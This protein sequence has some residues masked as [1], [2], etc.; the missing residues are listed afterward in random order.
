MGFLVGRDVET[1]AL[2]EHQQ[3]RCM[4]LN[5]IDGCVP[6]VC[7]FQQGNVVAAAMGKHSVRI[8]ERDNLISRAMHQQQGAMYFADAANGG[9]AT[10]SV[11]DDPL[12]I[13]IHQPDDHA[14]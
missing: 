8:S 10:E 13:A 11:T 2:Q 3:V 6:G 7:H 12:D 5:F 9:D 14:G 1:S 4:L